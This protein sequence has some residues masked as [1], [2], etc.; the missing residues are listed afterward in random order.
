MSPW[1]GDL[2]FL[3]VLSPQFPVRA[4]PG[5]VLREPQGDLKSRLGGSRALSLT[6]WPVSGPGLHLLPPTPGLCVFTSMMKGVA[7]EDTHAAKVRGNQTHVGSVHPP[8]P[9]ITALSPSCLPSTEPAAWRELPRGLPTWVPRVCELTSLQW[10][11]LRCPDASVSPSLSLSVSPPLSYSLL[12][13]TTQRSR[14]HGRSR[15]V[16]LASPVP[17]TLSTCD[18]T[19]RCLAVSESRW[20]TS[21]LVYTWLFH[22]FMRR[23]VFTQAVAHCTPPLLLPPLAS[24]S[25]RWNHTVRC[26]R[27]V[28]LTAA[29]SPLRECDVTVTSG[30]GRYFLSWPRDSAGGGVRVTLYMCSFWVVRLLLEG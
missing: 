25:G 4:A 1:P 10:I 2:H 15:G 16:L 29:G 17:C 28:V 14:R 20:R 6:G 19:G 12:C 23:Y 9:Q 26:R 5:G 21:R 11:Y 30:L 27:L 18:C 7:S 24:M 8:E 22:M 13:V 3:E